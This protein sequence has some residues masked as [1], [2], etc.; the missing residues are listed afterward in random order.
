MTDLDMMKNPEWWPMGFRLPLKRPEFQ[1][2][3]LVFWDE[4]LYL[5]FEGANMMTGLDLEDMTLKLKRDELQQVIDRGWK[6]D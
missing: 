4:D 1:V 2:A 3:V 5:L 6:V